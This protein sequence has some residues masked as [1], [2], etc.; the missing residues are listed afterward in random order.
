M[1]E[2]NLSA[3][4]IDARAESTA[5][6][7]GNPRN[8]KTTF[9]A[10]FVSRVLSG[11]GQAQI[12]SAV[13]PIYSVYM[14]HVVAIRNVAANARHYFPA[15]SEGLFSAVRGTKLSKDIARSVIRPA[16]LVQKIFVLFVDQY[17]KWLSSSWPGH[18]ASQKT[19]KPMPIKA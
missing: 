17:F 2:K 14:V 5:L 10:D 11:R 1:T 12:S 18:D 7:R 13:I 16:R 4:D 19:L 3:S 9:S 6:H 8:G 15:N